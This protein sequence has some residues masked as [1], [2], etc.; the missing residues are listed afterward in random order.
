MT[1]RAFYILLAGAFLL[2][3]AGYVAFPYLS[4]SMRD[5]FGMSEM[6]IGLLFLVAIGLR[7]DSIAPRE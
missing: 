4:V 3:A 7:P 1:N 2:E 5:S 6:D